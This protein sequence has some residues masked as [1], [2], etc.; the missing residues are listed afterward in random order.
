MSVIKASKAVGM[1]SIR[2]IALAP[3]DATATSYPASANA[4]SNSIAIM[5]SSSTTNTCFFDNDFAFLVWAYFGFLP[6]RLFE[7]I[8]MIRRCR[9]S[10][11]DLG[12]LM[13]VQRE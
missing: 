2:A 5:A 7:A 4:S 10:R 1:L 9:W 6:M 3:S 12:G 13:R 11:K 8:L